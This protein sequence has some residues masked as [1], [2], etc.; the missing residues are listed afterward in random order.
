[1]PRSDVVVLEAQPVAASCRL[2]PLPLTPYPVYTG[3]P[4]LTHLFGSPDPP[5]VQHSI[6]RTNASQQQDDIE[7]IQ[8]PVTWL[9]GHAWRRWGSGIMLGYRSYTG[10]E[11]EVYFWPYS[12]V[13]C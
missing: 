13:L 1:M 3:T 6:A 2:R 8:K 11:L 9:N 10:L 12:C 4:V 5:G 7:T